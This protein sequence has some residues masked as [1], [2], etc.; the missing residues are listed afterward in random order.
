MQQP[1]SLHIQNVGINKLNLSRIKIKNILQSL[2][3]EYF[4]KDDE[5]LDHIDLIK[6]DLSDSDDHLKNLIFCPGKESFINPKTNKSENI[7][8][9]TTLFQLKL[10]SECKELFI[11]GTF[12]MAPK[13]YYQI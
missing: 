5:F 1:L 13:K 11:D 8:F 6:I 9:F 10:I 12:K 2:R 7:V 4:P 3:E